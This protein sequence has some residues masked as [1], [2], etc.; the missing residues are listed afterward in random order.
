MSEKPEQPADDTGTDPSNPQPAS[1]ERQ[2]TGF[3]NVMQSVA[4]GL[5]GVQSSKNRERDFTHGKAIHF[6]I[7]GLL[8][9]LLF[10]LAIW[11]LVRYLLATS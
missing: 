10:I 2:G 8:G 4:A 11:M 5:I 7:G 3:L 9:T 1:L 6:I